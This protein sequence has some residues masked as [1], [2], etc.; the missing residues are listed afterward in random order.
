MSVILHIV[1]RVQRCVIHVVQQIIVHTAIHAAQI[2]RH[3]VNTARYLNGASGL[4]V[5]L[6]LINTVQNKEK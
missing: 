1:Q 4:K 2:I 6:V 3:V 5:V